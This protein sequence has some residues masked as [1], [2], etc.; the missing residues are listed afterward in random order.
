MT[1]AIQK[2]SLNT[3]VLYYSLTAL[4]EAVNILVY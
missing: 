2:C 4:F 1:I 3:V